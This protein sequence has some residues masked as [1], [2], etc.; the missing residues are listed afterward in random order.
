MCDLVF[1]LLNKADVVVCVATH[2][3]CLLAEMD[4][5]INNEENLS[6]YRVRGC[7]TNAFLRDTNEGSVRADLWYK[8][9][10]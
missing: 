4:E 9:N 8:E 2:Y 1:L 6:E 3:R 5:M 10:E 7:V